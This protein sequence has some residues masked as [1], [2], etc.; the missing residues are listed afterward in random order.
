VNK[1]TKRASKLTCLT[2]SS[3]KCSKFCKIKI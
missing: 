2:F 1:H 3:H